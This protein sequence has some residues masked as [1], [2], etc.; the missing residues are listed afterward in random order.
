MNNQVDNNPNRQEAVQ[1][2]NTYN[3][4]MHKPQQSQQNATWV[5]QFSNDQYKQYQSYQKTNPQEI[6]KDTI[7]SRIN[8]H[9]TQHPQAT[10]QNCQYIPRLQTLNNEIF[11][12][13]IHNPSQNIRQDYSL[14]DSFNQDS[15][16]VG[17]PINTAH[18][19]LNQTGIKQHQDFINNRSNK[20]T[21]KSKKDDLNERISSFGLHSNVQRSMPVHEFNP[22]LDMRPQNTSDLNNNM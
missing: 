11:E 20:H 18:T 15:R 8:G 17:T 10:H 22:Y 13:R 12:R 1:H 9:S 7:N 3:S 2:P 16:N 14:Q 5:S 4:R 6:K 19:A 21:F